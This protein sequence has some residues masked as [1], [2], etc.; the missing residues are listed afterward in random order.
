MNFK[1]I[2]II[3]VLSALLVSLFISLRN[4]NK[5]IAKQKNNIEVLNTGM[6]VY[7][8]KDSINAVRIGIIE[9][10]VGD[11]KRHND[12]LV[13]EVKNMNISLR[14][15]QTAIKKSSITEFYHHEKVSDTLIFVRDTVPVQI[16]SFKDEWIDFYH[17]T[18]NFKT[19]SIKI[20]VNDDSYYAVHWDRKGFWPIRFLKKKRYYLTTKSNNPYIFTESIKVIDVARRP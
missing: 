6:K 17:R 3:F 16:S 7:K 8:T 15:L 4:A 13:S 20:K 19:D 10:S 2:G 12:D 9:S 18:V 5:T 11:L 1:L 14:K